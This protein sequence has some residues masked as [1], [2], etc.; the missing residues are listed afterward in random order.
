MLA[1]N[2]TGFKE[3]F[4]NTMTPTKATFDGMNVSV[5][6]QDVVEVNGFDERMAYG[7][8]DR[9][10]GERLMNL[11]IKPIQIRYSAICLHLDHERCYVNE[12]DL[13]NNKAIRKATKKHKCIWTDFG[14]IQNS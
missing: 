5:W 13:N 9:E 7:G 14:L 6:K 2:L 8:E 12:A 10:L 4:L 3:Q 11:G 1:S